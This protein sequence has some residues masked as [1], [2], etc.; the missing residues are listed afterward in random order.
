MMGT[1]EPDDDKYDADDDH[2]DDNYEEIPREKT[3]KTNGVGLKKTGRVNVTNKPVIQSVPAEDQSN[4]DDQEADSSLKVYKRRVVD[5]SSGEEDFIPSHQR[6]TDNGGYAHTK[7]SR[8][9]ISQA[10]SGRQPWNKGKNRSNDAKAKISAGVRARNQAILVKKLE[11]LG[12]TEDEW[13]TM[14]IKIKYVR[15]RIRRTNQSIEKM[16]RSILHLMK[17]FAM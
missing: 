2:D 10:N 17:M 1:S 8:L 3:S 11:K 9:R 16:M 6:L 14:R 4:H 13:N 15:E 5:F 7:S 12:M